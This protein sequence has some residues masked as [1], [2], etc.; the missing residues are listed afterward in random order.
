MGKFAGCCLAVA[1]FCP[2]AFAAGGDDGRDWALT[3]M[4]LEVTVIPDE[5]T[6][7]VS[8]RVTLELRATQ[9]LGPTLT[10]NSR[11]PTME[12]VELEPLAGTVAD[13]NDPVPGFPQS[14]SAKIRRSTPWTQGEELEVDF[15]IT[16]AGRDAMQLHTSEA[17]A[18]A[19]WVEAWYPVPLPPLGK[20]LT[21]KHGSAPGVTKLNLPA[22][23]RALTNGIRIEQQQWP[24]LASE[25]WEVEIPVARSFA[26]GPFHMVSHEVNERVVEVYR[27]QED[28][29]G[30]RLQAESLA[31]ALAAIEQRFGDYPYPSCHLVEVPG[32]LFNWGASSEQGFVMAG[33][34]GF[35]FG[36]NLPLFA[37]EACHGWWGNLVNTKGSGSKMCSEAL[38]Q[39]GAVIALEA[40]E[41]D[42]AVTEFLEN[43][44]FGYIPQQCARG[45]FE[46]WRTGGD[47][48]LAEMTNEPTSHNLADS[49][50]HWVYHMLRR[51]VGDEVFFDTLRGLKE[52]FAGHSMSLEDVR[53]AFLRAAPEAA[54]LE[55][56]FAQW[57]DRGGA[58]VL[59]I[60]AKDPGGEG[61]RDVEFVIRQ[62]GEAPYELNLD[63]RITSSQSIT[64]HALKL[65]NE[66]H[67]VT[68]PVTG[69]LEQWELDPECEILMW[70]PRYGRMPAVP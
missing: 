70:R 5:Q 51:R 6:V 47:I 14:R 2:A 31:Q 13:L 60:E 54:R 68:L 32:A 1:L 24:D 19:S 33:T 25:V 35:Q 10:M 48:P 49:K 43:S 37:H 16:S 9:S 15:L 20:R 22:D 50:G 39:Y 67:T 34:M 38:A 52:R 45:Y 61:P 23:W 7:E 69:T 66:E 8:G 27:L 30:A 36:A 58:P 3:W 29:D 4:D 21:A 53:E 62:R 44:R 26:A 41:G 17:I 55:V 11:A 28:P 46:I 59:E 65:A 40:L 57:L 18:L 12:F 42:K 56:F 63:L 64:N